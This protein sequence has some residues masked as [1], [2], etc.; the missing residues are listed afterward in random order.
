MGTQLAI[1]VVTTERPLL[2]VK[3][4]TH[5]CRSVTF[6][7]QYRKNLACVQQAT[8]KCAAAELLLALYAVFLLYN[9]IFLRASMVKVVLCKDM[10]N[11]KSSLWLP[12]TL[13]KFRQVKC[14]ARPKHFFARAPSVD[15]LWKACRDAFPDI[16]GKY[17][18]RRQWPSSSMSIKRGLEGGSLS[19]NSNLCLFY[20]VSK[21]KKPIIM[22]PRRPRIHSFAGAS[23]RLSCWPASNQ[24]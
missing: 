17:E 3:T 13:I 10:F 20:V 6:L 18:R 23:A 4:V 5:S 14:D 2:G 9:T 8:T 19:C 12:L 7:S 24:S 22:H 15:W 21:K 1:I 11:W 16:P